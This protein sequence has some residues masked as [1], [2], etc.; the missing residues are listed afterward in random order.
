[1]YTVKIME[2]EECLKRWN[3]IEPCITKALK[4]SRGEWTSTEIMREVM[5]D[6]SNFHIWDIKN[7]N[8]ETVAFSSSRI[9]HYNR[10]KALHIITLGNTEG[11]PS[12]FEEYKE[13]VSKVEDKAKEAGLQ[14]LEFTGRKGWLKVL[15][16][17]G[18]KPQ[19]VTMDKEL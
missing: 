4:H 18:Y 15:N 17:L 9:N 10:Y 1:M 14:R 13:I 2:H 12:S 7:S 8:D 16:K 5:R 11:N 6:P 3:E 19:Y